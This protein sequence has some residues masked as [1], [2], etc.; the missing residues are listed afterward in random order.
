MRILGMKLAR[1]AVQLRLVALCEIPLRQL[2]VEPATLPRGTS[3]SLLKA[4]PSHLE[5]LS[6]A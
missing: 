6:K 4:S 2:V 1:R 3:S 5:S